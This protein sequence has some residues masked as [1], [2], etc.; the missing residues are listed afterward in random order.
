MRQYVK[1]WLAFAIVMIASFA[2]LGYYGK[3]IYRQSPPVPAQVIDQNGK[4]LFTGEDIKDGQNVWQSMGGYNIG[5]VW[6]HGSYVAPDWTADWLHREAI[7]ILNQWSQKDYGTAFEKA[8]EEQQA[9]LKTRLQK[10]LRENTFDPST[11]VLTISALRADA[12]K[13]F[14]SSRCCSCSLSHGRLDRL[15]Q[16]PGDRIWG[17]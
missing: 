8:S 16:W 12:I 1:L 6:G 11:G 17:I 5:T 4:V 15:S 10:E 7:Y 9:L 14:L 13:S 2:V 3:E